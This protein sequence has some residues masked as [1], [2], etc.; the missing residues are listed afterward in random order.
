[1][2]PHL[3]FRPRR[4]LPRTL[5]VH[6]ALTVSLLTAQF[7][8]A[9]RDT[10][11]ISNWNDYARLIKPGSTLLPLTTPNSPEVA[12]ARG[13]MLT[14][15]RFFI[16]LREDAA[17]RLATNE[18][19]CAS[20]RKSSTLRTLFISALVTSGKNGL[21]ELQ[22]SALSQTANVIDGWL[23]ATERG[24]ITGTCTVSNA[25]GSYALNLNAGW[26]VVRLT[27][28]AT[29]GS[30]LTNAPARTLAWTMKGP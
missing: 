3:S 18:P 29:R 23:Y 30:L 14:G 22:R 21:Y 26:N 5:A 25:T 28:S 17:F 27:L 11:T 7:A 16:D 12:V 10:G 24:S 4:R 20:V 13:Q 8:L 6:L 9:A 2:S 15:G 1:M 19:Q